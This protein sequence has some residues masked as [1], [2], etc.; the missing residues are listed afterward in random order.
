LGV[1]EPMMVVGVLRNQPSPQT[2]GA[3]YYLR[4]RGKGHGAETGMS[5][6]K[7]EKDKF[8]IHLDVSQFKP[9]EVKLRTEGNQV[10]IEGKHEE[11]P[12]EHGFIS[13][14]FSRKYMLPKDVDMTQLK[15]TLSHDGTL[16]I[17]APKQALALPQMREI[18]IQMLPKPEGNKD[19]ANKQ[20]EEKKQ[21]K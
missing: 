16:S 11:R 19:Q 9:E 20:V 5:E 7:N 18:P 14:Q 10:I 2:G 3:P 1:D 15:S 8:E 4:P 21:G 12:D 13:R 6:V 17:A